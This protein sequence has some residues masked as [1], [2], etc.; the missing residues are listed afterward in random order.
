[1]SEPR[2]ISSDFVIRLNRRLVE[3]S[4]EPFLLRD[5]GL[6]ESAL[7][8]P[9]NRWHYERAKDIGELGLALAVAIAR[10]HPFAQGN[11]RT[12][13][14]AMLTFF[15][16]NGFALRAKDDYHLAEL[17]IAVITGTLEP[18]ILLSSMFISPAP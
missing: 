7:T 6:L 4:G 18:E 9:Q 8:V 2:W 10:N 5:G 14:A 13:W 1:M 17:F 15:H 12:A 3:H 11:K 16:I